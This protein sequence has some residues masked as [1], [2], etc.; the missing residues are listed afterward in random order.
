MRIV[1]E[2]ANRDQQLLFTE[3][4]HV[5]IRMFTFEL[6]RAVY[7]WPGSSVLSPVNFRLR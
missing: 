1:P 7:G 6:F 2:T 3:T 4:V 5:S